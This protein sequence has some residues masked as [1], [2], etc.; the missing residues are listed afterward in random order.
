LNNSYSIRNGGDHKNNDDDDDDNDNN[1]DNDDDDDDD[2]DDDDDDNNNNDN[3]DGCGGVVSDDENENENHVRL[4]HLNYDNENEDDYIPPPP[5][6][7]PTSED[8]DDESFNEEDFDESEIYKSGSNRKN[9]IN[10]V[11]V[12]EN[13]ES[14]NC[15]N[16]G[17]ISTPIN[18]QNSL[19]VEKYI[20]YSES[21]DCS[22]N[23]EY[24]FSR[25]YEYFLSKSDVYNKVGNS[26]KRVNEFYSNER[27]AEIEMVNSVIAADDI[28]EKEKIKKKSGDFY[29]GGFSGLISKYIFFSFFFIFLHF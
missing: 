8:D 7:S 19:D 27:K 4:N 6:Y 22:L 1:D 5:I 26:Y 15:N 20:K 9:L 17:V 16:S 10:F 28:F 11:E 14:I 23:N 29:C 3:D 21:N 13:F 2:Y 18:F 24:T 12:N 25:I